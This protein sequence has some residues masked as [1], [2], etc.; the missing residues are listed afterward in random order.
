[1]SQEHFAKV[2][3][4]LTESFDD[5]KERL[6]RIEENVR[7]VKNVKVDVEELKIQQA[8][9]KSKA[10]SAHKRIDTLA[11][12]SVAKGEHEDHDK[13]LTKLEKIVYWIGTTIIGAVLLAVLGVV[14]IKP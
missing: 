1:M 6:I 4:K 10:D 12:S 5:F 11:D 3:D 13:R 9:L 8:S 14:L 2:L 7:D